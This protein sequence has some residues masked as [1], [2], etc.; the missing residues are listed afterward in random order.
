MI[1]TLFSDCDGVLAD[2]LV[3]FK[4]A[5]GDDLANVSSSQVWKFIHKNPDFYYNL[6]LLAGANEYWSAICH[7]R[8]IVLTGCPT[9]GYDAAADAKRQWVAKHFGSDVQVITCFSKDKH[10]HMIN[11]G[12]ILIDDHQK[13]ITNWELHNGVGIV[14]TS[15]DQALDELKLVL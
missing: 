5:Y 12:D 9:S 7:M 4:L 3:G 13:N 15:H 1:R 14:L 6:P 2:F 8:P 10:L 11:P